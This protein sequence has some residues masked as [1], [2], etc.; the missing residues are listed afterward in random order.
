VNQWKEEM[1]IS[2]KE[3]AAPAYRGLRRYDDEVY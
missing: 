2:C 1:D 3:D